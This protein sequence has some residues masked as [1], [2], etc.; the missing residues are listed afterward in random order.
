MERSLD[1]HGWDVKCADWHPASSLIASGGKDNLVKLFDPRNGGA[2][3][4]LYGHK[5]SMSK[6]KWN[7]NGNWL[8]TAS[9][10]QLIKMYDIRTMK[11]MCR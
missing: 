2:L 4:T 1:G 11:E 3:A 9:R 5:N 7:A 6:V 10:D 8:L